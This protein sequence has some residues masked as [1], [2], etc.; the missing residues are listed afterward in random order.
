MRTGCI[1]DFFNDGYLRA[2]NLVARYQ[3][4]NLDL[5]DDVLVADVGPLGR[6]AFPNAD[7]TDTG[8]VDRPDVTGMLNTYLP[9]RS[10]LVMQEMRD[11]DF[12]PET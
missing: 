8:R 4:S 10:D 12:Y 7:A 5:V 6:L 2:D 1:S 9:Q 11:Y 3:G